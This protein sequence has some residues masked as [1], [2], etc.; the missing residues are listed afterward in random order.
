MTHTRTLVLGLFIG[1][2]ALISTLGGGLIAQAAPAPTDSPL[3]HVSPSRQSEDLDEQEIANLLWMREEEKVARDVYLALADQWGLR[4]F[5]NISKAEQQ[6][7]DA[8]LGLINAYGLED[9]V[10]DNPRGVFSNSE[11]QAL[12]D[13]LVAQGSQSQVEALKVGTTV[14]EVDIIDL[15]KA[16]AHSSHEDVTQAYESLQCGSGNHL[17]AFVR[18]LEQMTGET[19]TPQYLDQATYDSI[20]AGSNGG[21]GQM[22]NYRTY[23][24]FL[25]F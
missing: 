19:Y 7:M 20:I 9:P 25:A 4:I 21:C 14:E 5:S 1:A 15:Q 17:R 8:M 10:G 24:P 11:L 12:Y 13:A 2:L 16:I 3:P 18:N 23:Q 6:H 22:L